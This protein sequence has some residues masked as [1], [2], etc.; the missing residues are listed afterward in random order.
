MIAD[1][2]ILACLAVGIFF[3]ALGI[4][5]LLRF[6][7]V[8]TRMH[9]TTKMTTFGS[10]FTALSVI[11][12]GVALFLS[13][14]DGQYVTLSVHTLIAAISLAFTNAVGSHAIA[15]GAHKAGIKPAPA[16]VDRLEE[17]TP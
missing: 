2:L 12:Y 4:A 3:N 7:D 13:S 6:P 11:I 1:V 15:R 14:G 17:F 10:M 5:G 8:Y 9:A 16:I